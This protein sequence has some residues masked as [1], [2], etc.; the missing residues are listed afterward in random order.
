MAALVTTHYFRTDST[1]E[2]PFLALVKHHL[3]IDGDEEN[4]LLESYIAS[5][6]AHVEMHCDRVLVDGE[7]AD[8]SQMA[9]TKDVEQAILMLVGHWY[10]N[11]E[12]VVVG[13]MSASVQL[14]FDRLLWY[15]KRF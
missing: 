9:L 14:G 6:K 15:R 10:A 13:S 4:M 1:S 11:R 2:N 5:A 8:A 12:A 3:R 7:A